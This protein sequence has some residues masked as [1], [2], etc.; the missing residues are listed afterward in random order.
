MSDIIKHTFHPPQL[1]RQRVRISTWLCLGVWNNSMIW[2]KVGDLVAIISLLR[3]L[4]DCYHLVRS[5]SWSNSLSGKL[6]FANILW[7]QI[8]ENSKHLIYWC[9]CEPAPPCCSFDRHLEEKMVIRCSFAH[10]DQHRP[11][12]YIIYFPFQDFFSLLYQSSTKVIML[13][14]QT[15]CTIIF[16][17]IPQHCH[18]FAACSIA[19]QNG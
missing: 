14:T 1:C 9:W 15:S 13:S 16:R 10:H 5:T 7:V 4:D 17:D 2:L 18:R 12:I 8:S 3:S 6:I 11:N 19:P